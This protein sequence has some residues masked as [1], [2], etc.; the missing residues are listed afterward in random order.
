MVATFR[1]ADRVITGHADTAPTALAADRPTHNMTTTMAD[2]LC[3]G[4]IRST[5]SQTP[6]T[7]TVVANATQNP[8][9]TIAIRSGVAVRATTRPSLAPAATHTTSAKAHAIIRSPR[10]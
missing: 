5:M 6:G 1:I 9:I 8:V 2:T 3:S 7:R 10:R 4:A